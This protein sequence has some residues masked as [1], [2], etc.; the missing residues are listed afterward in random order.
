MADDTDETQAPPEDEV[1]TE[2]LQ[3]KVPMELVPDWS[4]VLEKM[5]AWYGESVEIG[6]EGT[7]LVVRVTLLPEKKEVML[8][9]MQ[10]TWNIFV[11]DR[12]RQGR[13]K[14]S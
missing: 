6:L 7:S 9:D 14:P 10:R 5:G 13:W 12:K 4:N 8:A 1:K 11:E 3:F 2:I